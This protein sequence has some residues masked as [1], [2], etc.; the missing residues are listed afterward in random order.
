VL[1]EEQR[2]TAFLFLRDELLKVTTSKCSNFPLY[3]TQCE[4][5]TTDHNISVALIKSLPT[6]K[7]GA[8]ISWPW[9]DR[10]LRYVLKET[11]DHSENI[12]CHVTH[13]CH[14]V[15]E[16]FEVERDTLTTLCER[17]N[18]VALGLC[19]DCLSGKAQG[20]KSEGCS[21]QLL[22]QWIESDPFV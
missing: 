17:A 21:H 7:L 4:K 14:N 5:P 9:S 11:Y 6:F 10:P 2:K 20:T 15:T 3:G 8:P 13:R 19:L 1:V 22:E 12:P 16:D 18:K